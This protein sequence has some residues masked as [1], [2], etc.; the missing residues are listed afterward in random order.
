MSATLAK[1]HT[2]TGHEGTIE[3]LRKGVAYYPA[4]CLTSDAQAF[5][6]GATPYGL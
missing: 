1:I 2:L 4:T 3:A 6:A 5:F